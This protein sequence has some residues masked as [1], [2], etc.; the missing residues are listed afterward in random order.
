MASKL[1]GVDATII[2]FVFVLY[3]I[4]NLQP[5]VPNGYLGYFFPFS[6][7]KYFLEIISIQTYILLLTYINC[8]SSESFNVSFHFQLFLFTDV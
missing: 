6:A 3:C 5:F 1:Y 4:V 2:I 8:L 7:L